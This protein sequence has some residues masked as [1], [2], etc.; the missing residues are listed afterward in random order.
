MNYTKQI[1][2]KLNIFFNQAE[3]TFINIH[4]TNTTE[5]QEIIEIYKFHRNE[6]QNIAY[7]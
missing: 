1:F 6:M 2:C 4:V 3:A 5:M 7:Q